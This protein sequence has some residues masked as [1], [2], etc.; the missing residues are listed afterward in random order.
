MLCIFPPSLV[1]HELTAFQQGRSLVTLVAA[2]AKHVRVFQMN[3]PNYLQAS[4]R[5]AAQFLANETAELG[6]P[7]LRVLIMPPV[8]LHAPPVIYYIER[9]NKQKKALLR[10]MGLK[11]A[12]ELV[13]DITLHG[14]TL[15]R[16][17][18]ANPG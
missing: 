18:I 16:N 1:E 7:K 4:G 3:R 14:H 12:I 5:P 13:G 10:G 6:N 11:Q 8:H 2:V 15:E 17:P 9:W